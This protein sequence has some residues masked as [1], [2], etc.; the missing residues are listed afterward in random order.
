MS[1]EPNQIAGYDFASDRVARSPVTL[2][3]FER[4]KQTADL[5]AEDFRY[6]AMAGEVLSGQA[7]AMVKAWRAKI[8]AQEHLAKW[9]QT[10]DGH[11]DERYK[12]AVKRRFVQWVVDL[13]TRPYDQAWLDYQEEIGVRH[14]P[15]KK[16]VTD[17]ADTPPVVP[18]RYMVSF[19][20]VVLAIKQFLAG[21]GH[22]P[23]EVERMHAAWTKAVLLSI[24]L[25]CRPYVKEKLW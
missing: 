8:G 24:A 15:D 21:K 25:W 11:S 19:V 16:N 13:C 22:S 3:D 5:T 7:E 2:E 4:L 17:D 6:L 9:F 18:L 10:A 14:T 1:H 12:A 23:E 20:P